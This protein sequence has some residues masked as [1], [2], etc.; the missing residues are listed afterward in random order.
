MTEITKTKPL[1]Q[2]LNRFVLHWGEMGQVWGVNRSVSQIHALLYVSDHPIPAEEIASVL[3]LA[4]SNVSNSL[5]ELLSWGLIRRV[6]QLGDRRDYFEAEADMFEMVRRIAEGRK[7]R[8]IDPTLELLRQC[9]DEA[10]KDRRV[11]KE[12]R[13]RLKSMLDVA[14]TVDRSF[15][16]VMSLPSARFRKFLKLGNAIT[17]LVSAQKSKTKPSVSRT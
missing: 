14:E 7:V 10:A 16:A 2:A 5:K 15:A 13:A 3:R 11:S 17:R 9:R 1:P 4:R 12:T 6:P 8:E